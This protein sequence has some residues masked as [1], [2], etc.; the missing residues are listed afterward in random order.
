VNT[1]INRWVKLPEQHQALI[2]YA[3]SVM[4]SKFSDKTEEELHRAEG[5]LALMV[6]SRRRG[7]KRYW[8]LNVPELDLQLKRVEVLQDA[9]ITLIEKLSPSKLKLSPKMRWL[10]DSL[11]G[12]DYGA[13]GPRGEAPQMLQITSDGFVQAGSMF[14]GDYTDLKQNL[15]GVLYTIAATTDERITF[16]DIYKQHV[17]DWRS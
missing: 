13:R 7:T 10:V 15:D 2:Q 9:K 12:Q 16:W 3:A 6:K 1:T 17:M 14:I 11:T 8:T 5:Q 4:R